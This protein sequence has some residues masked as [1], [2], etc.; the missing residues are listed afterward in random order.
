MSPT[1]LVRCQTFT[2]NEREIFDD[3]AHLH[4]PSV[5]ERG[6][7]C[8]GVSRPDID[9]MRDPFAAAEVGRSRLLNGRPRRLHVSAGSICIALRSAPAR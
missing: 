9:G 4:D 3:C 6:I 2:S 1:R 8:A 5:H 7:Q